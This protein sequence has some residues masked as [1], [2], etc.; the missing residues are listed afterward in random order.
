[1]NQED[2]FDITDEKFKESHDFDNMEEEIIF[3]DE[4]VESKMNLKSNKP[5]VVKGEN[6]LLTDFIQQIS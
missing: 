1:M 4:N 5:I 3:K 2:H 6:I